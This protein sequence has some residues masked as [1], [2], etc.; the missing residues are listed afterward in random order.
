[1][2]PVKQTKNFALVNQKTAAAAKKPPV[3]PPAAVPKKP[4]PKPALK[5]VVAKPKPPA[6]APVAAKKKPV[7]KKRKAPEP[8]PEPEPEAEPEVEA[9]PEQPEAQEE[10]SEEAAAD[11]GA[12]VVEEE[13][14]PIGED[15]EMEVEAPAPEDTEEAPE[16]APE[17]E[18][19]AEPEPEPEPEPVAPQSKKKPPVVIRNTKK[20]TAAPTKA[21]AASALKTPPP[22]KAKTEPVAPGAP[23]KASK[24]STANAILASSKTLTEALANPDSS[25]AFVLMAKALGPDADKVDRLFYTIL[26]AY[27]AQLQQQVNDA[28]A[29]VVAPLRKVDQMQKMFEQNHALA[30]EIIAR[31]LK[32]AEGKHG[33][34]TY[35]QHKE[36]LK[37]LPQSQ[38]SFVP[39]DLGRGAGGQS[40]IFKAGILIV[41]QNNSA[42]GLKLRE[43]ELNATVARTPLGVDL[44]S[45][46]AAAATSAGGSAGGPAL[47]YQVPLPGSVSP[48]KKDRPNPPLLTG[49]MALGTYHPPSPQE[50]AAAAGGSSAPTSQLSYFA[51][52]S[53]GDE[54]SSAIGEEGQADDEEII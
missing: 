44:G 38:D 39:R 37:F 7:Q 47:E 4:L 22:K 43:Q 35:E 6:A 14:A 9:E 40:Q 30:G 51:S 46:A 27:N 31:V 32:E 11:E 16:E 24:K 1:M 48:I 28:T 34:I 2:P 5:K 52:V 21:A 36:A 18:A 15:T 13:E 49:T 54:E 33:G 41:P 23:T 3:K 25:H 8:E 29:E 19:E 53:E 42:A 12:A 17:Q 45:G 10:E 26:N 50:A 20:A